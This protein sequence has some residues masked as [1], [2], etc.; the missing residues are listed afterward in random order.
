MY[1]VIV[2]GIS[3]NV[4]HTC[5]YTWDFNMCAN[6]HTYIEYTRT[7]TIICVPVMEDMS[8]PS[9]GSEELQIDPDREAYYKDDP[10]KAL[11]KFFD[12]EGIRV[13]E[14]WIVGSFDQFSSELCTCKFL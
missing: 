6:V 13:R 3:T 9:Q 12:K 10:K 11:K 1:V 2:A 7:C 14:K 4:L 8:Q 5:S